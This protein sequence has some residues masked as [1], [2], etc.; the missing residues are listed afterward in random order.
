MALWCSLAVLYKF[1][2]N[3]L[4][5]TLDILPGYSDDNLGLPWNNLGMG[6]GGYSGC[7]MSI[8]GTFWVYFGGTLWVP[9]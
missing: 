1:I 7:L 5:C 8:G 3:T 9:R 6:F 2:A 4:W